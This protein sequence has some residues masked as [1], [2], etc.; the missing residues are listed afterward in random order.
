MQ[1]WMVSFEISC[2]KVITIPACPDNGADDTVITESLVRRL[3]TAGMELDVK[4]I[5]S[6]KYRIGNV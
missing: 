3:V 4:S 5:S 1:K 2:G 6:R